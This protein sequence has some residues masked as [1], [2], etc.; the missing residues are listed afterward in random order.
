MSW[1]EAGRR[2]HAT[3]TEGTSSM[4]GERL[5]WSVGEMILNSPA[6]QVPKGYWARIKGGKAQ[7][8]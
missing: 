3:Q 2:E 5:C 1:L 7:S 6:V 4:S 8:G